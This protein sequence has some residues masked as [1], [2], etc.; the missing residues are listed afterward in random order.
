MPEWQLRNR[1]PLRYPSNY[2]LRSARPGFQWRRLI[3]S[4]VRF[5]S[6]HLLLTLVDNIGDRPWERR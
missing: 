5:S 3:Y 4:R 6:L 1:L 2:Q